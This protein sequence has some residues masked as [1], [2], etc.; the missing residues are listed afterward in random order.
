MAIALALALHAHQP[1]GNFDGVIEETYQC[2]YRPFLEAAARRPWLRLNLHYSGYLLDWLAQRHPEHLDLL[3]RLLGEERVELLGGGYFEPILA[4]IPAPD[5]QEQL[6]RLTAA[7]ATHFQIRPRGAWLAERVWEPELPAVLAAAGIEYTLLD[8]AHFELAGLVADQLRGSWTTEDQGARLKLVPC[9]QFL[10]QAI[11]FRPV[12]ESIAFLLAAAE[13]PAA[14][15]GALLCM[16]DDLEKFGSWP[17]TAQHVYGEG[18]LERFFDALEAQ[19]GEIETVRLA[20]HLARHPARGLVYLPTASYPE[21]MTWARGASWR[22]FLARYREANLMHKT[23]WEL[24]RRLRACVPAAAPYSAAWTHL[25]AAESNDAYWHG[26]FGG[27]YTPHLRNL[28]FGHLLAADGLIESMAGPTPLRR[29]DLHRDGGEVIELRT[30]ELRAVLDPDEGGSLEELDARAANANLINSIQRR[31]EAYHE[32]L[33]GGVERNPAHLP[34]A[35]SGL[36]PGL[37]GDWETLLRYDAYPRSG[38][39]LYLCAPQK[40][41]ADYWQQALEE[42]AE[43]AGGAYRVEAAEAGRVVLARPGVRKIYSM[44]GNGLELEVELEA[45][46]RQVAVEMVFNPL[47]PDAEDRWLEQEGERRGLRWGGELPPAALALHDGWRGMRVELSAPGAAAWWVKPLY[48]VSQAETGCEAL[49]QGSAF[50][51]V[52][53]PGTR[54]LRLGVKIFL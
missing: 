23:L 51:A 38:G 34:E 3:R 50:A 19:Q 30:A 20:D 25:L 8:D 29:H 35:E 15:G 48:T 5:Q 46:A 42:E 2:S 53:A 12:E 47:A 17:H 24:G 6:A 1:A 13:R 9:N 43:A 11:P 54:R 22:G 32:E 36:T 18:W 40:A 28:V 16:G 26:W 37:A 7:L 39:R 44:S 49:Y 45:H 4:V 33:R 31:P 14:F 41:F 27:L 52:W 21:M 10:R